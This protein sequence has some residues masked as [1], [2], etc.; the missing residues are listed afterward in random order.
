MENV[1]KTLN[2]YQLDF[3]LKNVPVAFA[4]GLRRIILSD[5]PTVVVRDVEILNN[6]SQMIH[7]MLRHRIEMLPINVKPEEAAVIRDTRLE[8]RFE[9]VDKELLIT[10]DDIVV[11][12]PRKDVILKDRDLNTPH[13][14]L[15]LNPNEV[16]HIRAGL[17]IETKGATHACVATFKNH[18]DTEI[19]KLDRDT[20][21]AEGGDVRVFDNHYIQR[22]YVKDEILRRAIVILQ[23]KIQEWV[24]TDILREEAGWYRIESETEGHTI[25][26]LAQY[27]MYEGGLVDFVSY[28]IP[29]PLL[30]KMVLRFN[31]TLDPSAVIDKFKQQ[32]VALCESI[33]KSL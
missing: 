8:L 18:I 1:H 12:G 28:N 17:G 27:M 29:H 32:A 3:E 6:S 15:K 5:I 31:T 26:A 2:G 23:N 4:N 19:A 7:E 16:V 30:P 20:F 33:L 13:L 10:S 25:G 21:T 9:G 11:A 22:S 24:K 14:I